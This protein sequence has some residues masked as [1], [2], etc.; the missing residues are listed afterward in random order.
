MF[1]SVE[2]LLKQWV[3]QFFNEG[4]R[5]GNEL[6]LS[7]FVIGRSDRRIRNVGSRDLH[8]TFTKHLLR[9][10]HQPASTMPMLGR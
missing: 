1:N 10:G 9:V 6:D 5:S 7:G 8:Y 2:L 4:E 3:Q